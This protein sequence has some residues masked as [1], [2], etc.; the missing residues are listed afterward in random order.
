VH[1][2]RYKANGFL[3]GGQFQVNT[4]TTDTQARPSVAS[5][6]AG[7]FVVVWQS[8]GSAGGDTSAYSVQGQ[9]Y[10]ASGAR[11]G[12]QFQVNTSTTN[13]QTHPVVAIDS[14]GDFVVVWDGY[15]SPGNDPFV[16]V[17]GQ[18]YDSGGAAVGGPFQV[19]TYTTAQQFFPSIA[20]D[21]LGKDFVVVWHS[22]GSAG[23]DTDNLSIQGQRYLPEPSF[24][25]SLGAA[26]AMVTALARWANRVGT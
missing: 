2:Q 25:P 9:R 16:S 14:Y 22:I 13:T 10:D 20:S 19:N 15:G 1:G 21:P 4:Y 8:Y 18:I 5:D 24:V 26:L 6:S 11:V 7:N 17:Q 23:S 3:M 12:G